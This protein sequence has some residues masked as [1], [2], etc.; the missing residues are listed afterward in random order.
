[1]Y[2]LSC[3]PSESC[4]KNA[5]HRVLLSTG[6]TQVIGVLW[7]RVASDRRCR[8]VWCRAWLSEVII[9]SRMHVQSCMSACRPPNA[10]VVVEEWVG[11]VSAFSLSELVFP[12]SSAST[13]RTTNS[14]HVERP[15]VSPCMR[16]YH[17]RWDG[18]N[19]MVET[20]KNTSVWDIRWRARMRVGKLL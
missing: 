2:R 7:W 6:E 9:I 5:P 11:A 15:L 3:V 18:E 19:I 16:S 10:D 4:R 17:T 14:L 20:A 13:T 8:N 1:M 12:S